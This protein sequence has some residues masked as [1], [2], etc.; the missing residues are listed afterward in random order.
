MGGLG[1]E[2]SGGL[3]IAPIPGDQRSL[4]AIFFLFPLFLMQNESELFSRLVPLEVTQWY[5]AG[6]NQA[7]LRKAT[8]ISADS[9]QN[10]TKLV[11]GLFLFSFVCL[12][13]FCVVS[14]VGGVR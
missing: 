9:T 7:K 13:V 1:G 8:L 3:F 10:G 12:F 5:S 2:A 4:V 6:G 14:G 11:S